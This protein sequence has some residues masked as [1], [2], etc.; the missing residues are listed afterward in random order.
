M[1]FKMDEIQKVKKGDMLWVKLKNAS[2]DYGYGEVINFW[3][4]EKI[5]DNIFEFHCLVNG[6]LRMG[7]SKNIID[8]P[9]ARMIS[10]MHDE[11]AGIKS[12]LKIKN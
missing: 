11:Q 9:T 3:F 12:V 7:L 10:K 6:G 4:D 2:Y 5:N 8:K 1:D